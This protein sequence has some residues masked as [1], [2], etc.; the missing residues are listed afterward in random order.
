M[1]LQIDNQ[2]EMRAIETDTTP[3]GA[4]AALLIEDVGGGILIE[5][6]GGYLL[7]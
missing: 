6:T 5:A 3:G 1:G 2:Q 4:E 7:L